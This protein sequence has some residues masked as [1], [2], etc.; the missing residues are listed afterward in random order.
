MRR[1]SFHGDKFVE[2]NGKKATGK[3]M[4]NA[5]TPVRLLLWLI[6]PPRQLLTYIIMFFYFFIS[7]VLQDVPSTLKVARSDYPLLL[8][9]SLLRVGDKVSLTTL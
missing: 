6:P 1:R 4:H 5:F 9:H 3:D 8:S 7:R 2:R